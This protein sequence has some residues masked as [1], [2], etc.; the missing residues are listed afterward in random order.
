MKTLH[1][2][3]LLLGAL[4]FAVGTG[5]GLLGVPLWTAPLLLLLRFSAPIQPSPRPTWLVWCCVA[6]LGRV[7]QE[8]IPDRL[9]KFQQ[10]CPVQNL[11]KIQDRVLPL[12]SEQ[13]L[14]FIIA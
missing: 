9:L 10:L 13:D 3:L 5:W 4:A 1:A 2:L 6:L 8:D 7:I 14:S 12:Q 11:P